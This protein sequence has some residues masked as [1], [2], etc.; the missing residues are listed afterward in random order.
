MKCKKAFDARK[1]KH[2]A[3]EI[4]RKSAVKR[5]ESGESAEQVAQGLGMNRRTI[6][7]WLS[8]YH[9]GG[10][11][12]LNA[13]PI[14]G[15]PPKVN[16]ALLQKLA[17][18]IRE[19]NPLQLKFEFALWTLSIIRE[20]LRRDFG[21]RISEV[22]VGRLMKRI[23]F[24]PQRPLYRAWQQDKQLVDSWVTTEFLNIKA[25]AKRENAMIYFFDESGIRS[26]YHAGTT[27]AERGKTP[28][29]KATGA[30][31]GFNILSAVNALGQFRFMIIDKS[32]NATIFKAFLERL[33]VG[34]NKK[35]FLIVDGHPAHKAKLVKEFLKENADEIELFFL[36]AY[37]PELNPDELVWA[38]MKPRLSRGVSQ[39]KEELKAKAYSVLRRI[40][41]LPD[42]VISFFHHPTC[43]YAM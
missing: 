6:Y 1:L 2:D 35:I 20:L 13:K 42:L 16:A 38:Y 32:V 24:T 34:A 10:E 31:Y 11:A 30:R 7:R 23:G 15:A 9:Y 8:A 19:K 17:S 37:S 39:T 14:P 41:R 4:L 28:V 25:R 43:R 18:I 36:P 5:I 3:L 40:Q 29:I 27:W 33:I 26:D 22:S 21:I 12:A